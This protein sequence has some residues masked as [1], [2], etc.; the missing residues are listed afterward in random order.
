M[1]AGMKAVEW[2]FSE[3]LKVDSEWSVRT[4]DGF[5]WW[6]DKNAQTIEVVG[7]E[8]G[9]DGDVGSFVSV[10]TELLRS[11]SLGDPELAAIHALLMPF[12]SM[13]G[14]VYDQES[15]TLSLC[16]LVRVHNGISQWMN[17]L[18]SVAAVLQI[19]E[20][21]I[22]GSELARTLRAEEALSGPPG[23]GMRPKPDEMAEIIATLIAPMGRQPSRWTPAE[24]QE[25]VDN[26]MNQ[27]PAL[28][29]NSGGAGFTVE[30]PHGDQSSLCQAMADQAHPRYGN[31]LLLLQSFPVT[32]KSEVDGARLALSLNRLELSE[33]PFGYGFGS[34]AYR[35]GSLH[36]TCFFPNALYRPGLLPN[37][38]ISCAQ[39]AREMSVRLAGSE[40]TQASFSPRRSA[41]GRMMDRL[42]GR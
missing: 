27:P 7:N 3:Q 18:I 16:S 33:R 13:A 35:D 34:Y 28:L 20:A 23:R 40:W 1:N 6:A 17:R 19:G 32:G 21:R 36:F 12:A 42:R 10:R 38:Y 11:L 30:F 37:I 2:L 8:V 15:K 31:G 9:P 29:A 22:I 26:Y 4:R 24:F 39:R 14:P 5:R 41:L 25:T